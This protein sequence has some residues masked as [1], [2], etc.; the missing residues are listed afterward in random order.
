MIGREP[1]DKK[2]SL[3][4]KNREKIMDNYLKVLLVKYLQKSK[5]QNY[6]QL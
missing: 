4:R 6:V 2:S 5:R 3:E 1:I